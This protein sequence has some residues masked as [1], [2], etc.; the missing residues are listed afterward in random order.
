MATKE[1]AALVGLFLL[2]GFG[3]GFA[4]HLFFHSKEASAQPQDRTEKLIRAELVQAR[5]IQLIDKDGTPR[6]EFYLDKDRDPATKFDTA[7]MY[8]YGKNKRSYVCL[9]AGGED[10][11]TGIEIRGPVARRDSGPSVGLFADPK[12][13]GRL[14]LGEKSWWGE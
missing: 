7:G 10:S 2:A 5:Q 4:S 14:W 11:N 6:I 9:F 8:V 1:R 3:G 13:A 12:S